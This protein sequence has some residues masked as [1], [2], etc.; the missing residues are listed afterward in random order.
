MY[1]SYFG[2]DQPP[3]RITPDTRLFFPGG[4]RGVVLEALVYAILSGEGIVKVVGEVGSGK[5]MLCRMLETELPEKVE[6]IYLANPSLL[7]GDIL[8]AIAFEL[9]ISLNPADGK[10]EVMH[11]LHSYLLDKHM[12]NRRVVM[13]V[14]EAQGMPIE[15]LEEIRLLSNLETQKEKLLQIV[16]FGQPELDQKLA[17]Q[18]IRQLKDR[19]TYSFYLNPFTTEQVREYLNTRLRACGYNGMELFST[20]AIR[21]LEHY[22]HG[23]LRRINI[24]ADKALL[25]A[26]AANEIKVSAKHVALAAKDDHNQGGRQWWRGRVIAVAASLLLLAGIVTW[27][28]YRGVQWMGL[29]NSLMA[30]ISQ[31]WPGNGASQDNH[32]ADGKPMAHSAGE[33]LQHAIHPLPAASQGAARADSMAHST[34]FSMAVSKPAEAEPI[35]LAEDK[36]GLMKRAS[37]QT[38]RREPQHKIFTNGDARE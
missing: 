20:G 13:F 22:S 30:Q 7:P 38:G 2:L 23:L 19:I 32:G 24:L 17:Q 31:L 25:A 11:T 33:F 8:H 29:A 15:T 36:D 10:L 12:E 21:A 18:E 6:I 34:E 3:F 37:E 4:N 14:E 1:Y 35:P 5:T 9:G 27:L 16:L 28:N 26:Y